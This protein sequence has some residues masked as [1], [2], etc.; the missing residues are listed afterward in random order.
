MASKRKGFSD[1]SIGERFNRRAYQAVT[2][3]Y[4]FFIGSI[5]SFIQL[6]AKSAAF[7][8]RIFLRRDIGERTFGIWS[9]ILAYFWVQYFMLDSAV[10]KHLDG[11]FKIF[12]IIDFSQDVPGL[13]EYGFSLK[14]WDDM[15]RPLYVFFNY[16]WQVFVN[17]L[18]LTNLFGTDSADN[19]S[20]IVQW[21]SWIVMLLGV[22]HLVKGIRRKNAW[23]KA[24]SFRR[25][26]SIFFGL[27][28]GK[29]VLNVTITR[30][31]LLT[32]AEPLIVLS[33]GLIV[34]G[35][36]DPHSSFGA[37]MMISAI[38]LSA[39]EYQEY[40]YH[41]SKTLDMMDSEF[42]SRRLEVA[43]DNYEAKEKMIQEQQQGDFSQGARLP[44]RD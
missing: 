3:R 5:I 34:Y 15:L 9:I 11:D 32:V 10:L 24:D 18:K 42:E 16:F 37:F 30:T 8:I 17:L 41:Q 44:F 43:I 20:W 14:S 29:K 40:L 28:E 19:G 25:G 7:S 2:R 27:L 31:L 6:V 21:Y 39:E 33:L 13:G 26:D 35:L 4:P 1:R 22:A 23:V 36:S 12:G 38:A